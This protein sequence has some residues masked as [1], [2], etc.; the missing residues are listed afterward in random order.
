MFIKNSTAMM[1]CGLQDVCFTK[2][3]LRCT[4][5]TVALYINVV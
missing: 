2:D 4:F 5:G 3:N 1:R